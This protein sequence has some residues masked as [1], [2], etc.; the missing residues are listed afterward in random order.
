[1]FRYLKPTT[2]NQKAQG[3]IR[4]LSLLNHPPTYRKTDSLTKKIFRRWVR[5]DGPRFTVWVDFWVMASLPKSLKQ[6]PGRKEGEP[7]LAV[8]VRWWYR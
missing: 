6:R 7:N 5:K 2:Q 1:M 4:E 3:S 8:V